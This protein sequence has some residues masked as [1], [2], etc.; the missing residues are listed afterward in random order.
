MSPSIRNGQEHPIGVEAADPAR[1]KV[2][3]GGATFVGNLGVNVKT[4]DDGAMSLVLGTGVGPKHAM[5]FSPGQAEQLRGFLRIVD[6]DS[7]P[8][9]L[10]DE[11]RDIVYGDRE[12]THGA[13]D[14][15]LVAIAA[16][17]TALLRAQLKTGSSVTPQLVCLLMMGRKLACA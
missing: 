2:D 5:H 4:Y 11:A 7:R 16:I 17:W 10:L 1:A 12:Q 14:H 6:T 13:P 3:D 15:N 8:R 9:S